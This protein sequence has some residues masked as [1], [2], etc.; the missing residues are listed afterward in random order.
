MVVTNLPGGVGEGRVVSF[1]GS[2]DRPSEEGEP[3]RDRPLVVYWNNIPA[4]YMVERFNALADG[5]SLDFEAWFNERREPDRSWRVDEQTWRFRYRYV[6]VWK[7]GPWT[8]RSPWIALSRR[9]DLLVSLYAEPVFLVSWAVR[10]LVG[11]KT[12]FWCVLTSDTWVRR[13]WWKEAL[14]RFV[15]RRVDGVL[16]TGTDGANYAI[17]LGARPERVHILPHRID[18]ESFRRHRDAALPFRE[19]RRE[20]LGLSGTTFAYVGRLWRGK[21]LNDLM[22]AFKT[23]QSRSACEVSLLLI[24]DGPEES[25]LLDFA[26]R[27]GLRNVVLG[28]FVDRSELPAFLGCADVFVFPTLGDP[29]GM[30]IDEAMACSLPIIS[31]SAAGEVHQRVCDGENG[32]VVAPGDSEAL[33]VRMRELAANQQLRTMMGSRSAQ[34]I[35]GDSPKTWAAEF[36]AYARR[37]LQ[38]TWSGSES[39]GERE[40]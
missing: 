5:G 26:R 8:I 15:F 12:V 6:K 20:E 24:G 34:R 17:S 40:Q 23:V 22:E 30:V 18:A 27:H 29:Y 19:Q 11:A 2:G 33:A 13:R 37:F 39:I 1:A 35:S 14:K 21:G 9:P 3:S 25:N 31:T 16:S 36:E 4:P 7:I 28:G 10:W 38:V 32:F